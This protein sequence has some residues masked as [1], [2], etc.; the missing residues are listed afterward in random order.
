MWTCRRLNR[1]KGTPRRQAL[2]PSLEFDS[3]GFGVRPSAFGR[4]HGF[5]EDSQGDLYKGDGACAYLKRWRGFFFVF[6]H[7]FVFKFSNTHG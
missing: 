5:M 7:S 3:L 4:S 1:S 6:P 2:A